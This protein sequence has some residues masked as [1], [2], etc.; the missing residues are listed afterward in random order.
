M[1]HPLDSVTNG[2]IYF[3]KQNPPLTDA[4]IQSNSCYNS[5]Q[6]HETILYSKTEDYIHVIYQNDNIMQITK[7][8]KVTLYESGLSQICANVC[9]QWP[10]VC[11]APE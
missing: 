11:A 7:G 4:I 6:F 8:N 5:K 10:L 3:N 2:T 1:V 9:C